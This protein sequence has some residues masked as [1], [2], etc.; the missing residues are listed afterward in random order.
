MNLPEDHP[1][2]RLKQVWEQM[3][4]SEDGLLVIDGDKLYIPP[5]AREDTLQK[6]HESHCG[7]AKT[8]KTAR[9]LYFWPSMKHDI[10]AKIDNCEKCQQL[11][12]SKPVEPFKTTMA[13][14]PM[15]HI[16]IDLFHVK[17]KNYMVT[18]DRY[19]GYIWVDLL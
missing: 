4:L 17:G 7:Y 12:P 13:T 5:G 15:E 6:L 9:G 11:Q 10:R 19:S 18:A 16:S 8:L 14:F 2:R 3:S 1:A